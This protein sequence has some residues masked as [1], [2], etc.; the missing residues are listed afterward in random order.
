MCPKWRVRDSVNGLS[1][2][3]SHKIAL[4]TSVLVELR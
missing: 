4:A 2:N 1:I 3:Y